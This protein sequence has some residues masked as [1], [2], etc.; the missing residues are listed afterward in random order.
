MK[1]SEGYNTMLENVKNMVE[2][3]RTESVSTNFIGDIDW[4]STTFTRGSTVANF[5]V[6]TDDVDSV[7]E[8]CN[9]LSVDY[10]RAGNLT[11]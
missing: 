3:A 9:T 7:N 4:A 10:T 11:S 2:Y 6:N 5:D 8:R 1:G